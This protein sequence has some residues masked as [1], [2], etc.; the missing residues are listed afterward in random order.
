MSKFDYYIDIFNE[1]A[2]LWREALI[3]G[4]KPSFFIT[5]TITYQ[6]YIDNLVKLFAIY[7]PESFIKSD[8]ISLAFPM[9]NDVPLYRIKDSKRFIQAVYLDN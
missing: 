7:D 8:Y 2:R 5:D 3:E 9:E 4:R 1:L 6:V